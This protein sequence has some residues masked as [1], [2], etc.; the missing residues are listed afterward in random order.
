VATVDLVFCSGEFSGGKP[1]GRGEEAM[2]AMKLTNVA[3]V[4][5]F[6]RNAKN[7]SEAEFN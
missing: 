4:E 7:V 6:L 1:V 3:Q 5:L 2:M